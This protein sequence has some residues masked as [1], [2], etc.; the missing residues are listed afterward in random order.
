MRYHENKWSTNLLEGLDEVCCSLHPRWD[1]A[2]AP[3]QHHGA[4][5]HPWALPKQTGGIFLYKGMLN[6]SF[7]P[8][9]PSSHHSLKLWAELP[10]VYVVNS[11]FP[12]PI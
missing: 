11:A 10:T 8:K 9:I 6:W 4:A 1:A 12:L 5:E 2:L 3:A 7:S